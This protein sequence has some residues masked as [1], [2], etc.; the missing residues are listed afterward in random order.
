M[1]LLIKR[2]QEMAQSTAESFNATATLSFDKSYP[3]GFNDPILLEKFSSTF[4]SLTNENS[5]I[6]RQVPTMYAE[7]F[8]YYQQKAAGIYIHLG[9]KDPQKNTTPYGIHTSQF[10]PDEKSISTGIASHVAFA[11]AILK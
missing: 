8:S 4:S 9:V 10:N 5:I 7:D 2:V 1:D 3:P 6:N 11:L